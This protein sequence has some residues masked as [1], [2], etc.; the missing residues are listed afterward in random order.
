MKI[1]EQNSSSGDVPYQCNFIILPRKE[2]IEESADVSGRE[3]AEGSS[4][5]KRIRKLIG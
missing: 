4:T 1:E 5:E 2:K 3:F